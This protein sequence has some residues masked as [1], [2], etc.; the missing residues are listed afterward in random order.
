MSESAQ[1][2]IP[3]KFAVDSRQ[4][5]QIE[6]R[7]DARGIVIGGMQQRAFLDH[8]GSEQQS[9]SRLQRPTDRLQQSAGFIRLEVTDT[10]PYIKDE[11]PPACTAQSRQ[12]MGIIAHQ[13]LY[14]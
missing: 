5:V 12:P 13:R 8:I 4:H 9:I 7:G 10:R 3:A 6:L 11:L 1:I 14:R 2:E